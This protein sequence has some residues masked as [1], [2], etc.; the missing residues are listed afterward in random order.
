M[1]SVSL[2]T[3]E[4]SFWFQ[5]YIISHLFVAES[6]INQNNIKNEKHQIQTIYVTHLPLT[7]KQYILIKNEYVIHTHT[8]LM[9]IKQIMT[10]H[11][12]LI[13][14]KQLQQAV[15]ATVIH[16]GDCEL[17]LTK[18]SM[19]I[20]SCRVFCS[21]SFV[22]HIQ[23]AEIGGL[24][25]WK[26]APVSSVICPFSF[27]SW[28]WGRECFQRPQQWPDFPAALFQRPPMSP[29]I[30]VVPPCKTSHHGAGLSIPESP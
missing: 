9:I 15:W 7:T 4:A 3:I 11:S 2:C 13:Q 28:T 29:I 22:S 1:L 27:L 24:Q 14:R 26:G 10:V 30:S 8:H 6:T 16:L 18:W 17:V 12:L 5:F 25:F 19:A 21:H 23:R 20:L